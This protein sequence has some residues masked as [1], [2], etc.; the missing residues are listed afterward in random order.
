MNKDKIQKLAND[1][2]VAIDNEQTDEAR[3]IFND[4]LGEIYND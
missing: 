1:G 4:I 2:I 3:E